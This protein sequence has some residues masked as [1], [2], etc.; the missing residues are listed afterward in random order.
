MRG[1]PLMLRRHPIAADELPP[2]GNSKPGG[3][4]CFDPRQGLRTEIRQMERV[5]LQS[6]D[7]YE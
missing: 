4:L 7:T 1:D 5:Y 3:L 2:A 6:L